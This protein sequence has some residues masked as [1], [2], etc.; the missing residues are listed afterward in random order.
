MGCLDDHIKISDELT[1]QPHHR[2]NKFTSTLRNDLAKV[3]GIIF[4][5]TEMKLLHDRLGNLWLGIRETWSLSFYEALLMRSTYVLS[6]T[7]LLVLEIIAF[8]KGHKRIHMPSRFLLSAIAL[9]LLALVWGSSQ[10]GLS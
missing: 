10:M 6:Y 7:L 5:P 1:L 8:V 9:L 4:T 2:P 3:L